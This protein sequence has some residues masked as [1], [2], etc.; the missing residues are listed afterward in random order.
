VRLRRLAGR[1][2]NPGEY[3]AG[4]NAAFGSWG[5]EAMFK[6]VFRDGAELLLVDDGAGRTVG[7]TAILYRTLQ[8]GGRA[9]IMGGSW[10]LPEARG[11]GVFSSMVETIRAIAA[12][13]GAVFIA[14][15]RR[16]N[17][18]SRRFEALGAAMHPT[19]YCRS[20]VASRYALELE[21]L[22]PDPEMFPSSFSYSA[23]QWR[24]QFLERPSARV[25]CVGRRGEW[26]A[27]VE[28]SED[29]DR[30]HAVSDLA[31]LPLLAAHAHARGRR[32][33]WFATRRP[34]MECEWTEG[35]LAQLPA[36][37][38]EWELQNGDRM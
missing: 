26:A 21:P 2:A 33:F 9:A 19:F 31:A 34:S 11:C 6:W 35:F 5:D 37:A 28:S 29:F 13:R 22:D 15:V 17:A 3:L 7:G 10:T 27:V 24:A 25:E 12:E 38:T 23:D 4:A 8:R 1:D 18:S 16:E 20:T 30:V 32:L 14:F 36:A